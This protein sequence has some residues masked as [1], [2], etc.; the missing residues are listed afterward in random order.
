MPNSGNTD[1]HGDSSLVFFFKECPHCSF[2]LSLSLC[3]CPSVSVSLSLSFSFCFVTLGVE[4]RALYM[5]GKC[6]KNIAMLRHHDQ[7]QLAEER[8]YLASDYSVS[9][10]KPR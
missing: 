2:S 4:T 7:K 10:G 5:L 9:S 3:L 6:L 8:A 1:A